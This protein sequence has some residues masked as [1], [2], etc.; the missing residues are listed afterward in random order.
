MILQLQG[1]RGRLAKM[2]G[3]EKRGDGLSWSDAILKNDLLLRA[4]DDFFRLYDKR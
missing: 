3:D 1:P 2:T 4:H